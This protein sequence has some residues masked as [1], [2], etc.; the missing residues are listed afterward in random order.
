MFHE[1]VHATI[2]DDWEASSG[3]LRAQAADGAFITQ[4]AQLKPNGEDLAESGLFAYTAIVTPNR[5]PPRTSHQINSIMPN[6]HMFF[7]ELFDSMRPL[8]QQ[9]RPAKGC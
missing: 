4:Y 5:L 8:H 3:W 7:R 9:I 6:R 1:S 2:D